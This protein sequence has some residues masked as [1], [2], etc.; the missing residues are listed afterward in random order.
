MSSALY[1]HI[2][3][4]ISKCNYCSFNSY[5]G[6]ESLQKRYVE[7]MLAECRK[8]ITEGQLEALQ[9]IFLGGGTPTL[10]SNDLLST[11][12]TSITTIF[13]T[14]RDCEFS[15]EA[16]PGTLDQ[17]KLQVLLDA[18][19]NRLSIG[20]QSFADKE[21]QA[22]SRSHSAEDAKQAIAMAKTAGF[23]NISIDLMYG[24]PQQSA[25]SW[26]NNLETALSLNIQHLS[27]YQLTVEEGTPLETM[28]QNGKRHLP[29][30]DTIADMDDITAALTKQQG[31]SQYEISNY[32]KYGF[33]CR[34][35]INYWENNDF[36]GIGA[37]A[38]GYIRGTRIK[39]INDPEQYCSLLETAQSV[40]LE[41]ECLD[42]NSSFGETMIMGLRMN[43]GVSIQK[44]QDRY[45]LVPDQVYGKTLERLLAN[46]LLEY[47]DGCL[48]LTTQGRQFANMVMAELV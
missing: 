43:C 45:G 23:K 30:E 48:R 27:L 31:L 10:L 41:K 20:V 9:T 15:I 6:L 24:L 13:K 47:S 44:L 14:E 22:I 3:F 33:Q 18:G 12:L 17:S 1:I 25:K 35:N 28:L 29:D 2:P 19:V 39:N 26:K 7:A 32:A 46:N 11:L 38:V 8:V 37:G 40:T 5:A 16:N 36:Y 34:H 21:L 42:K 4:C